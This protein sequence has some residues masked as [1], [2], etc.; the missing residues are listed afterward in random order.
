M[1]SSK[2]GAKKCGLSAINNLLGTAVW[3]DDAAKAAI[4]SARR[5]NNMQEPQQKDGHTIEEVQ[6]LSGGEY[7]KTEHIVHQRITVPHIGLLILYKKHWTCAVFQHKSYMYLDSRNNE[8]LNVS[9]GE[10]ITYVQAV[11]AVRG[12]AGCV[13]YVHDATTATERAAAVATKRA[14][15]TGVAAKR[16]YSKGN[17]ASGSGG[18]GGGAASATTAA[19]A[20]KRKTSAAAAAKKQAVATKKKLE[21]IGQYQLMGTTGR[22][23]TRDLFARR[24]VPIPPELEEH[25]YT[26]DMVHDFVDDFDGERVDV[27]N[28]VDDLDGERV[29]VGNEVD[30]A[31]GFP[32]PALDDEELVLPYDSEVGAFGSDNEMSGSDNDDNDVFGSDPKLGGGYGRVHVAANAGAAHVKGR[33]AGRSRRI[34]RGAGLKRGAQRQASARKPGGQE[35]TKRQTSPRKPGAQ[36]RTKGQASPRKPGAQGRTKGQASPRKPGAQGRTKGQASPR[37]PRAQGRSKGQPAPQ[38]RYSGRTTGQPSRRRGYAEGRSRR[39]SGP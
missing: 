26:V 4:A 2:H 25:N 9:I 36:G 30:G 27:G 6:V 17:N 37:K 7:L 19:P 20:A 3:T 29:D 24:G 22:Q 38:G 21:T 13:L 11:Q 8:C 1:D 28:E 12:A 32:E 39:R 5:R 33:F 14:A 34:S 18:G 10:M 23:S 31:F 35:R 15:A 16:K